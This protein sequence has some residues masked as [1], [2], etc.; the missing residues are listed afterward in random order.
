MA[1]NKKGFP[2]TDPVLTP[3]VRLSFAQHLMIPEE[4]KKMNSDETYKQW[5][6]SLLIP[7]DA[8]FQAIK[9]ACNAAVIAA[10]PDK[11]DRPRKF[12]VTIKDGDSGD[13]KKDGVPQSEKYEGYADHMYL[14]A[15]SYKQPGI[16][17]KDNVRAPLTNPEDVYSG[18]YGIAQIAA[19]AYT[20]TSGSGVRILILNFMKTRDGDPLSGGGAKPKPEDAFAAFADEEPKDSPG[21]AFGG[22]DLPF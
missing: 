19:Q 14:D 20:N 10:W 16:V 7:K 13:H 12:N 11:A 6:A 1:N 3:E 8:N 22:D 21:G 5:S 4:K 2:V 18:C 9:D 17:H 15:I